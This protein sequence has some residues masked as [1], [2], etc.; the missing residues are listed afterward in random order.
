MV[1]HIFFIVESATVCYGEPGDGIGAA[2]A[3]DLV[4][5][6]LVEAILCRV[7]SAADTDLAQEHNAVAAVCE[8]ALARP[9]VVV[10]LRRGP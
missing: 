7:M 8:N 2:A 6:R 5:G 10:A 3:D 9:G 4:D 1:D